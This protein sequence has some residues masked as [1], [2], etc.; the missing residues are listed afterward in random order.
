MVNVNNMLKE[1]MLGGKLV[2]AVDAREYFNEGV[3]F[4]KK[5]QEGFWHKDYYTKKNDFDL[6]RKKSAGLSNLKKLKPKCGAP[7]IDNYLLANKLDTLKSMIKNSGISNNRFGH[8]FFSGLDT[9][10]VLILGSSE[11]AK[12]WAWLAE[13]IRNMPV[14]LKYS[15]RFIF[16]DNINILN[17]PGSASHLLLAE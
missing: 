4:L 16:G 10:E 9:N 12:A 15:Y 7:D 5:K 2:Q 14:E 13:Q 11:C 3:K 8:I 6:I 17:S 1:E